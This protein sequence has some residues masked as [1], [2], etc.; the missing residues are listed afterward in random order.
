VPG[1][2]SSRWYAV[3]VDGNPVHVLETAQGF[4]I[5]A[6][7]FR[8]LVS[9]S[10]VTV[11]VVRLDHPP[12]QS[13]TDTARADNATGVVRP[14]RRGIAV[15]PINSSAA[16]CVIRYPTQVS[17]ELDGATRPLLIFADDPSAIPTDD[18][19]AAGGAIVV[20][21]GVHDMGAGWCPLNGPNAT[22]LHLSAGA[23]VYGGLSCQRVAHDIRVT[24]RG[25]LSG[26]RVTRGNG[27]FGQKLVALSVDLLHRIELVG[28]TVIDAPMFQVCLSGAS[29]ERPHEVNF[30]KLVS[31]AVQNTDGIHAGLA[32]NIASSMIVAGDDAIDVGQ[33]SYHSVVTNVTVWN[34]WGS[35]LLIS[36]NARSDTGN[37]LVSRDFPPG[38][39]GGRTD[40]DSTRLHCVHLYFA[41]FALVSRDIIARASR[42]APHRRSMCPC[43][44]MCVL[45]A[46]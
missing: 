24:G 3:L 27:T 2:A 30:V 39:W 22:W 1:L 21:P 26:A 14:L 32:I 37:A 6:F 42:Q 25:I 10:G 8:P 46:R 16:R 38:R 12:T 33:A 45:F 44:C 28:I 29:V 40:L 5:A 19:A 41:D 31:P 13:N 15:V 9:G 35:A 4:S 20:P 7:D 11:S 36:W 18:A 34:R 17:F 43:I 23:V